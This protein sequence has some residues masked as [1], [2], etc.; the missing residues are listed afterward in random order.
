MPIVYANWSGVEFSKIEDGDWES[1]VPTYPSWLNNTAVDDIFEFGETYGRRPPVFVRIPEPYNIVLNNTGISKDSIYV[2]ATTE[3]KTYMMCSLRASLSKNCSTRYRASASGGSLESSCEDPDNDYTYSR[4]MPDTSVKPGQSILAH[5]ALDWVNVA[6]DWAFTV[7]LSGGVKT[8]NATGARLLTQ[9]VPIG[10]PLDPTMPTMAEGLAALAGSTLLLSSL[11]APLVETMAV[12]QPT[13][14]EPQDQLFDAKKQTSEYRSSYTKDW[15]RGFYVVLA[16][17]FA[18]NLYCLQYLF[19][20]VLPED[21]CCP[22][23]PPTKVFCVSSCPG[24]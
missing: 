6:S 9:L 8:A 4:R 10:M 5:A 7:S 11:D 14:H 24:C 18:I 1:N 22:P 13:P 3:H 17:T 21:G 12:P 23:K 19:R 15:Q 20:Y 16:G 2:L